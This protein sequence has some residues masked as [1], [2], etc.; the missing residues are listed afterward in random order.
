[1]K[2]YYERNEY[3]RLK[4]IQDEYEIKLKKVQRKN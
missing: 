4:K 1:M 2:G 3:E